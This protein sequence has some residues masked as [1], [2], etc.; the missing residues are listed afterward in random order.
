MIK[1]IGAA[2]ETDLQELKKNI[3]EDT[4]NIKKVIICLDEE[5]KTNRIRIWLLLISQVF[6]VLYI[7]LEV[8]L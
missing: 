2:S 5:I 3:T 1:A 4:K 8:T 7:I 6:V